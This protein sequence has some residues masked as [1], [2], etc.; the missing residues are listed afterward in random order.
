MRASTICASAAVLV[1]ILAIPVSVEAAGATIRGR[2]SYDGI[3]NC[4]Q[5]AIRNFAIHAEGTAVLSTDRK[6]S[7]DMTTN[8]GGRSRLTATL[9]GKP[10]E[11]PGGSTSLNVIGSHTLRA[12][13]DY[14]N[15]VAIVTM[16]IRGSSCTMTLDNRLKPGKKV[17]TFV[18]GSGSVSY[19]ARPQITRTECVSF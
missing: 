16:T 11:A 10:T 7:L 5:P 18:S 14:P 9:G 4:Q 17:Y 12:V 1:A 3:A 6:A 15:N 8:T 13:R 2:F 19:C